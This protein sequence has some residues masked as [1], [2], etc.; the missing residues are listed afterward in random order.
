MG[1]V[2][3]DAERAVDVWSLTG[4]NFTNAFVVDPLCCPSRAAILKGAYAALHGRVQQRG[5]V[6]PV[7]RV[8]GSFDRRDL[9]ARRRLSDR[10]DR[11]VLQRLH[12]ARAPY[13]PPG[14]DRWVAFATSDVGGGRYFDYGLSMDGTL[15]TTVA[16]TDYSTDVWRAT[17]T[18]SSGRRIRRTVFST[19]RRTAAPTGHRRARDLNA[20]PNLEAVPAT[21]LREADV[22][23]KP[24][25]ISA[26]HPRLDVGRRSA[27]EDS[28]RRNTTGRRCKSV[29]DAVSIDP[30]R[31]WRTRSEAATCPLDGRVH[32]RQRVRLRRASLGHA[33]V[34]P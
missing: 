33:S 20:F 21:E 5:T 12:E 29:D 18:R 7:R 3:G 8:R 34:F 1:L 24:A 14:W 32:V 9:A 23:D 10:V 4:V 2:V 30:S 13:V 25:D 22:S 27:R 19:S 26:D 17:P 11:E 31:R 16:T 6:Q 15:L 28:I